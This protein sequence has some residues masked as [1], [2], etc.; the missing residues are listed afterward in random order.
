M[1]SPLSREGTIVFVVKDVSKL[2]STRVY[3]E[4]YR[5]GGHSWKIYVHKHI[6]DQKEYLSAFLECTSAKKAHPVKGLSVLRLQRDHHHYWRTMNANEFGPNFNAWGYSQFREYS[7]LTPFLSNDSLTIEASLHV[8]IIEFGNP[9][10]WDLFNYEAFQSDLRCNAWILLNDPLLS[11]VEF[12][13]GPED[14]KK[15]FYGHKFVLS[16]SSPV[17]QTMMVPPNGLTFKKEIEIPDVHPSAFMSLL[18]YV[19]RKETIVDK[20]FIEETLYAAEKYD[21]TRFVDTLEFLINE[22]TILHFF[23]FVAG[24]GSRH[25]LHKKCW[26]VLRKDADKIVKQAALLDI[27]EDSLKLILEADGLVVE[28]ID[29]FNA[30][31]KW[32]DQRCL[33]EGLEINDSN[34]KKFMNH[35]K[36]IRFP[37]MTLEEFDACPAEMLVLEEKDKLEIMRYI[38][39]KRP[40]SFITKKRF[41]DS[42]KSTE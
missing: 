39:F 7:L 1:A 10:K 2:T 6:H 19:Y 8:M 37:L 4:E 18:R 17:F 21:V 16:F 29:L 14:N 31:V 28:E 25:I 32:A 22:E 36:L 41:E 38:A 20:N 13:V 11:D 33:N 12:I 15:S 5:I 3:S 26:K 30:Y 35:L 27:P 42:T 24:I 34:R 23:P 40:T 9:F